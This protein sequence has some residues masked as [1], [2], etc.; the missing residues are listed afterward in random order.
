MF[1]LPLHLSTLHSRFS[2]SASMI[3]AFFAFVSVALASLSTSLTLWFELSSLRRRQSH[4][5]GAT[6]SS[7]SAVFF[8]SSTVTPHFTADLFLSFHDRIS[9]ALVLFDLY[10]SMALLSPLPPPCSS[11]RQDHTSRLISFS[12]SM[13]GSPSPSS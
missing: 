8:F 4:F 12:P 10:I 9:F 3:G 6:F 7:S 1:L 13:I 5:N 2:F 11:R